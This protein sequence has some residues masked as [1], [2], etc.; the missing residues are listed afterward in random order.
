[1]NQISNMKINKKQLK[2]VKVGTQS[3][4]YLG[5]IVDFEIE[6]DTGVI[7]NYCVKSKASIPGLFEKKLI[8]N[9]EQIISFDNQ[10]MIVEDNVIK[11]K[12]KEGGKEIKKIEKIEGAEPVI[13]SEKS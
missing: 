11:T 2:K 12:A 10:K 7:E 1:M 8:I 5:K 6:T 9:K 4:R 3:G 13:T